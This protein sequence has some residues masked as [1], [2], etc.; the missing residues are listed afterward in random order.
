MLTLDMKDVGSLEQVLR[1]YYLS[2]IQKIDT[3]KGRKQA[4]MLL[5][6]HLVLPKARQRTSQDAAYIQEKIGVDS[7]VLQQLVQFRLVRRLD[8]TGINPIYEISHDSLVEPILAERSRREAV[9]RFLKKYGKYFLLLLLFL[10]GVGMLFENTFDVLD[11]DLS[12][13]KGKK[14]KNH[15]I[16]FPAPQRIFAKKGTHTER[17][18]LPIGDLHEVKSHD[19]LTLIVDVDVTSHDE[20]DPGTG[21]DTVALDLGAVPL[22]LSVKD[23]EA[24]IC[25]QKDTALP[26]NMVI[27]LGDPQ[28]TSPLMASVT[29]TA[30]LKL[31]GNNKNVDTRGL[32]DASLMRKSG[33]D[34]FAHLGKRIV[35]ANESTQRIKLD[36][37]ISLSA[38]VKDDQVAADV[39][40]NRTVRFTYEVDIKP[41]PQKAA[42]APVVEY[43]EVA[44][45][46]VQYPDGTKRFIPGGGVP[47]PTPTAPTTHTVQPGETLYKISQ[48]YGITASALRKLNNLSDN[49]IQPGQ[50][51]KVR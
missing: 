17:F 9:G 4:R 8:K 11:E 27:P 28:A 10:F 40:K 48:T 23:L 18:I 14:V 20:L 2:Q 7:R 49:N 32:T 35:R 34:L 26:M 19:S 13:R 44:G 41:A 46:E 22:S 6:N 31:D 1:G 21:G 50:V 42:P 36:T 51:L 37:V 45:I 25:A 29:G 30:L 3:R 5:E 33:E 15:L 24:L 39:L 43:M 12:F 16:P 38:L 47:A